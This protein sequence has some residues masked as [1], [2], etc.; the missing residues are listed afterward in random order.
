[1]NPVLVAGQDANAQAQAQAQ[2]PGA[3]INHLLDRPECA[4]DIQKYCKTQVENTPKEQ[5]SDMT[6]LECLQDA[7]Y[8]DTETLS[9]GCVQAVWEGLNLASLIYYSYNQYF[10]QSFAYLR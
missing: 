10:S 4:A 3:N 8:S 2:A 6:V 5:L 1:M 7:G 9:P